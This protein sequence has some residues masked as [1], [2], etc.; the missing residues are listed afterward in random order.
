MPFGIHERNGDLIERLHQEKQALH[1]MSH[2]MIQG[3]EQELRDA[4]QGKR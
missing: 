2:E 1:T 3:L 4:Q